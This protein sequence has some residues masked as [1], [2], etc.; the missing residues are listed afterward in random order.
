MSDVNISLDKT[1]TEVVIVSGDVEL[2]YA[3][4][5]PEDGSIHIAR[6]NLPSVRIPFEQWGSLESVLSNFRSVTSWMNASVELEK[7]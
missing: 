3:R 4:K 2:R 1:K 6:K 5:H 7:S